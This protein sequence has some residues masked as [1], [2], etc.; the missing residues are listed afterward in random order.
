LERVLAGNHVRVTILLTGLGIIGFGL[1]LWY[2]IRYSPWFIVSIGLF[3]ILLGII[4]PKTPGVVLQ[5]SIPGVKLIVDKAVTGAT[6]YQLV[7]SDSRLVMKKLTSRGITTG[8]FVVFAVLGGLVGGLT[9][10][11]LEEFIAQRR[12]NKMRNQNTLTVVGRGDVELPY[13]SMREVQ[14]T[15]TS[16]KM[17]AAG[18]PLTLHFPKRYAQEIASRLRTIIP[19]NCWVGGLVPR[20]SDSA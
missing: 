14:L 12:R 15:G 8:V 3:N 19:A 7:F 16:L 1:V 10:V 17:V 11:S 20:P 2:L 5:P 13:E 9:G 6:I 18:R 4:T